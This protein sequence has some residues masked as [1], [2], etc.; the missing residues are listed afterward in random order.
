MGNEFG[1]VRA[2]MHCVALE[3]HAPLLPG[4]AATQ[5]SYCH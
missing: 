3:A 1:R 5:L 4:L 2:A